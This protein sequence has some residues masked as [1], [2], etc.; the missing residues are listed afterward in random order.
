MRKVKGLLNRS[1]L[2][3]TTSIMSFPQSPTAM[4]II[5][6]KEPV[7]ATNPTN[8]LPSHVVSTNAK[9]FTDWERVLIWSSRPLTSSIFWSSKRFWYRRSWV[10]FPGPKLQLQADASIAITPSKR[11][12]FTLKTYAVILHAKASDRHGIPSTYKGQLS[13]LKTRCLHAERDKLN[14]CVKDCRNSTLERS[15]AARWRV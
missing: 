1:S 11:T 2:Y 12:F 14:K 4:L 13:S 7:P 15:R 6:H 9:I 10:S 5:L 8:Q 3:T